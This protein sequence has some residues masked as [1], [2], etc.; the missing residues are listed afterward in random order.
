MRNVLGKLQQSGAGVRRSE[1]LQVGWMGLLGLQ[2]PTLLALEEQKN[3]ALKPKAKSVIFLFLFGGPSQLETFDMKPNAPEK[4][5]GPFKPISSRTSGL[6]LAE[7]LP[8]TAMVSD[9]FCAI[10]TVT[11][12]YNDHSGAGH[13]I[14]TGHRWQIPIRGGFSA[15]DQDVPS[16]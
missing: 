3:I 9:K 11:H 15:T 6:R 14:Q 16:M 12:N 5:R 2:V 4:I 8:K 10:R 13:Y 7:H 1:L